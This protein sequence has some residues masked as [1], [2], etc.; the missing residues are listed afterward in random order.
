[1]FRTHKH[2][3]EHMLLCNGATGGKVEPMRASP[4]EPLRLGMDEGVAILAGAGTDLST[5][6]RSH[7][8]PHRTPPPYAF[9]PGNLIFNRI[10]NFRRADLATVG[11]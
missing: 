3:P 2:I 6:N 11:G 4:G 9:R 10:T 7:R 1:M 5:V 8:A